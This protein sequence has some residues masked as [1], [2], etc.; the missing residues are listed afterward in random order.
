MRTSYA[1]LIAFAFVVKLVAGLP[2][3]PSEDL[4]ARACYTDPETGENICSCNTSFKRQ[5]DAKLS[6]MAARP[7]HISRN[8]PES[9][10]MTQLAMK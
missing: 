6:A 3:L 10:A 1:S 8:S 5:T 2:V 4:T 7:V 9:I